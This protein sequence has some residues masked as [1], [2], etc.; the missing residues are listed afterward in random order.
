MSAPSIVRIPAG[1]ANGGRF[2]PTGHAESEVALDDSTTAP[3]VGTETPAAEITHK[4]PMVVAITGLVQDHLDGQEGD[5]YPAFRLYASALFDDEAAEHW[6]RLTGAMRQYDRFA[7]P[8]TGEDA[9]E[10]ALEAADPA[11][12]GDR[13]LSDYESWNEADRPGENEYPGFDF[14]RAA[15][16]LAG[17]WDTK[18][19]DAAIAAVRTVTQRQSAAA[20]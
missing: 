9:A 11:V 8:E 16:D 12:V 3:A 1:T 4:S 19:D 6:T 5:L 2:A 13:S 14:P 15:E 20:A 17:D 7:D 18:V 10:E